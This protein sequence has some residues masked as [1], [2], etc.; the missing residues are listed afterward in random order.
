MTEI[1]L[2][3][4]FSERVYVKE[5]IQKIKDVLAGEEVVQELRSTTS[6]THGEI[7]HKVVVNRVK[8]CSMRGECHFCNEDR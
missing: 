3:I 4:Q 1:Q 7:I 5:V 6:C 8:N 2:T